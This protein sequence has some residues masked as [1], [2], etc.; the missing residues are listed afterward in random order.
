MVNVFEIEVRLFDKNP[1]K[2]KVFKI[3]NDSIARCNKNIT[4]NLRENAKERADSV[5]DAQERI[6]GGL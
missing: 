6:G 4:S 5:A 1:K 3:S 2:V